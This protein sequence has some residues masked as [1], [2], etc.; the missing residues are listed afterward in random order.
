MNE[1]ERLKQEKSDLEKEI[2][3]KIQSFCEN[4]SVNLDDISI[5][6]TNIFTGFVA[7]DARGIRVN[8]SLRI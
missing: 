3:E 4:N 2:S 8:L 6:V 7:P 5:S 1:I